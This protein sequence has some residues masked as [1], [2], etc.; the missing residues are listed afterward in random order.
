MSR[1]I[2]RNRLDEILREEVV[3]ARQEEIFYS[4]ILRLDEC[5]SKKEQLALLNEVKTNSVLGEGPLD[6]LIKQ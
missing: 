2:S 6:W 3:K 5:N 1:V 4:T